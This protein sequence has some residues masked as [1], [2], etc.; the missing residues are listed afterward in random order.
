MFLLITAT[1]FSFKIPF[2]DIASRG[3]GKRCHG[4]ESL[5]RKNSFEILQTLNTF[6]KFYLKVKLKKRYHII[7]SKS[8]S[9]NQQSP[10]PAGSLK[11]KTPLTISTQQTHLWQQTPSISI[12]QQ[13]TTNANKERWTGIPM[14]LSLKVTFTARL[15]QKNEF[16]Q[17]S[18]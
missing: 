2:S 17:L 15:L 5:K 14:F 11:E 7:F 1:A 18:A 4:R 8:L 10:S 3:G 12:T 9:P 16:S 13:I 6:Q